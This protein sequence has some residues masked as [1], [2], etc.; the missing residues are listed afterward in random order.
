LNEYFTEEEVTEAIKT[1]E[2]KESSRHVGF[3]GGVVTASAMRELAPV[4]TG[5][6]NK[7]WSSGEFSSEWNKGVLVPVFKERDAGECTNYRTITIGPALEK[8]YAIVVERRMTPWAEERGLRARGQAGFRHDHRVIDHLFT[9]RA[10]IDRAHA[11]KHA[12]AAFVDFSKAF[13]T[14]PRDLL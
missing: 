9:L 14:I 5:L 1:Y 11:G 6:F 8:L 2:A 13:D 12:F 3:Y 4:L 7:M 10:L